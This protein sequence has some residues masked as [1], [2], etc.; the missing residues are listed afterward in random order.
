MK[1][2]RVTVVDGH[3]KRYAGFGI[4][5]ADDEA[6]AAGVVTEYLKNDT[7]YAKA[8]EVT[9][10]EPHERPQPH[11]VFFNWGAWDEWPLAHDTPDRV[12]QLSP[13]TVVGP[14]RFTAPDGQVFFAQRDGNWL[15][16]WLD[17]NE[18]HWEATEPRFALPTLA[19]T[20]GFQIAHDEF[21]PWMTDLT[22]TVV[23][24]LCSADAD[25]AP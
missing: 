1:P 15:G 19:S 6:Q 13:D 24:A 9:T 20:L 12:E 14:L 7:A 16:F 17:G 22:A 11:V 23:E 8:Y 18:D 5:L 2:W 21:P 3:Y 10:V 25:E 4:V